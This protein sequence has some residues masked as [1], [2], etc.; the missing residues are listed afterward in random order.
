MIGGYGNQNASEFYYREKSTKKDIKE[1]LSCTREG[2]I[3]AI[4]TIVSVFW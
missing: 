3:S 2:W 1:N 4:K